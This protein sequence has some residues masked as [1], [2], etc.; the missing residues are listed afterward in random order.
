MKH[1]CIAFCLLLLLAT[2]CNPVSSS[3]RNTNA[4]VLTLKITRKNETPFESIL[5]Q[6]VLKNQSDSNLLV[7]TRLLVLPQEVSPTFAEVLLLIHDSDGNVIDTRH[8]RID[9]SFPSEE[10]FGLLKSGEQIEKTFN[11]TSWFSPS[12]FQKGKM[13]TLMVVYQNDFDVTKTIDGV[14]VQSWVGTIQSNDVSLVIV[15]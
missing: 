14:E 13:Y 8:S 11:L 15:P 6:I 4:L 1:F 7:N 9:F 2:S 12:D 3:I 5:G 10:N